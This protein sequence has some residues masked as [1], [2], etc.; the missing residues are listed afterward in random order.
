MGGKIPGTDEALLAD[1]VENL[2]V[3]AVHGLY[4]SIMSVNVNIYRHN[5]T[6]D[7]SGS[8][9]KDTYPRE[10]SQETLLI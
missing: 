6:F 8:E 9:H 2:L 1:E 4:C 10:L 7:I 3:S 5:G